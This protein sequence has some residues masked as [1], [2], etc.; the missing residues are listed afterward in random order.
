MNDFDKNIKESL[1]Q[2]EYPFD[3]NAWTQL[4]ARLDASMPVRPKNNLGR[5]IFFSSLAVACSTS[6]FFLFSTEKSD[7]KST[8]KVTKNKELAI[9]SST[10]KSHFNIKPENTDQTDKH[11]SITSIDEN[12]QTKE[13]NSKNITLFE[14][15]GNN[16]TKTIGKSEFDPVTKLE[17]E[18]PQNNNQQN[19]VFPII[20]SE[21]QDSYTI[22]SLN[23]T[24]CLNDK[25]SIQNTFPQEL[26]LIGPK[27]K[28]IIKANT[29][30]EFTAKTP[31]E[32]QLMHASTA[33]KIN[34]FSVSSN[35]KK[36]KIEIKEA[37]YFEKGIPYTSF[38]VSGLQNIERWS[39]NGQ[40]KPN[41]NKEFTVF[42]KGNYD[43]SVQAKNDLG[44]DFKL[45]QTVFVQEN[46]NLLAPTAFNVNSLDVRNRVFIPYAL[47]VR[48][49]NFEMIIIEPSSGKVIYR[50][51]NTDGWN[52]VDSSSGELIPIQKPYVWKVTLQQSMPGESKEYSGVVT[53]VD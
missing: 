28:T 36:G 27:E 25:I 19:A 22:T 46:Y 32:Y 30:F 16:T 35:D 17:N 12:I 40:S 1:D 14:K 24:Y 8:G 51:H 3:A 44:C 2:V 10:K 23:A 5:K 50:T 9:E 13:G 26:I 18:S 39:V 7:A 45:T 52:G 21:K 6:L 43:I 33:Q 53:R 29:Q 20:K 38:D 15:K 47:K 4:S 31:G 11:K 37:Y 41:D 48:E 34:T 49:V 42:K